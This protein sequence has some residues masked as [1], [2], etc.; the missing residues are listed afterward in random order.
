MAVW[1]E[2]KRDVT[3][4]VDKGCQCGQLGCGEV[5]GVILGDVPALADHIEAAFEKLDIVDSERWSQ[6]I[7]PAE[8]V[9]DGCVVRAVSH[10]GDAAVVGGIEQV[11]KQL[12]G[13]RVPV[14]NVFERD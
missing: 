1:V 2:A 14:C 6:G 8:I 9:G 4:S 11:D 3:V 10:T 12:I 13:V 5:K 7:C